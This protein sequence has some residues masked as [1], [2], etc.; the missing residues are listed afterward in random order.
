MRLDN[1]LDDVLASASHLKVLRALFA[2]PNGLERSGRDVARRAG[3]S[4][5]RANQVLADLA[6][7]GLVEIVRQ[8]K[9]DLYQL[10]IQHALV[11]PLGKLFEFEARLKLDLFSLVARELK[12]RNL[13]VSTARVFGSAVRGTMEPGSDVD[14]A[15]VTSPASV[16]RVE[17][18]AQEIVDAVHDRFGT[19]LNVLVGA[20]SLEALSKRRGGGV[21]RSIDREGVDVISSTETGD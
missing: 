5:P 9:T 1:P 11:V 14:L 7:Q 19:C 12:A 21:W 3:I 13:P 6:A 10:N 20:P 18:E 2:I 17:A 8:P 16:E 4:H 15:L